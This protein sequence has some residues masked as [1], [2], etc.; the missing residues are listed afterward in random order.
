MNDKWAVRVVV[1]L[2][3]HVVAMTY[4][5]TRVDMSLSLRWQMQLLFPLRVKRTKTD[6]KFFSVYV[7]FFLKLGNIAY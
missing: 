3:M 7:F 4:G 1:V 5:V 6:K 2:H